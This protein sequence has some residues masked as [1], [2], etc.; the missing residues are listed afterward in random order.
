MIGL[1]ELCSFVGALIMH[2]V[3]VVQ[4]FQG[5]DFVSPFKKCIVYKD[6]T[7][8]TVVILNTSK[9]FTSTCYNHTCIWSI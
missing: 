1:L 3:S 6:F 2:H 5:A 8:L 9:C 4:H 7:H